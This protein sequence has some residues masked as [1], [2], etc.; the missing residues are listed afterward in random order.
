[1][2]RKF[3]VGRIANSFSK[4]ALDSRLKVSL[5][6]T[7][8]ILCFTVRTNAQNTIS[9][10][11]GGGTNSGAANSAYLP[12]VA[13][14]VRDAHGNTY[15]SV[16]SLQYI[17]KVN[18]AGTISV[19]AG[20]GIAG[21]SGDG[22]PA[23]L[24]KLDNPEGL[25]IDSSGNL[26]VADLFNY[27]VRRIDG[28]TGT[29]STVAGSGG[30]PGGYAG[31]GG[32]ATS[33]LLNLPEAVAVD[34][35]GNLF[36][37]DTDNHVVRKVDNSA[38]H[39]I[40]TYAG[41]GTSGT[42]GAANGDGGPATEAQLDSPYGV[43]VDSA[44]IVFIADTLDSV[45]RK[46][47][48][49]SSHIIT[50]YAGSP[51]T[52]YTSGGDGG[53]ATAAGLSNPY[54]VFVDALDN[55]FIADTS[56]NRIRKVD[57]STGHIIST[58]A[59]S[60]TV[61]SVSGTG[62]G[63]GGTATSAM[64]NAPRAT[65]EDGT[66]ALL[67]ID[68]GHQRVRIVTAGA[69]PTISNFAGGGNGGDGGP[70]LNAIVEAL[71]VD[72]DSSG[73]VFILDDAG[74]RVR[75]VDATTN[76]ITT[77]AGTG[78]QGVYGS[79]NGNN[80]PATQG[81][82][83]SPEGM[84]IDSSG[85]LYVADTF[86]FAVR[87]I[88]AATQI[89][90]TVAGNGLACAVASSTC[91]DGAL[92]TSANL[93]PLGVA[94]DAAGNIYIADNLAN[95]I[96][97]VDA[98]TG[99]IANFAGT[100]TRGY[101]GD[102][103]PASAATMNSPF[104]MAFD[105][106]GNLYFVD[107]GNNVVRKIDTTA[108]HTI[109]TVAFNGEPTFGGD[110]G[111]ALSASMSGPDEVAVDSR[112]N[113]FVGG[114][115]DNVVQRVD[116]V[117]Q[118]IATVA[119]DINDL[120]G[121]FSGDGGPATK[122]L[123]ANFGLALDT[124]HNLFIADDTHVR[125]VHMTP[126]ASIVA[127]FVPFATTV[128]GH[129]SSEQIVSI[130][131]T[132][133]DDL[134][135]TGVS[136][137]ANF[138]LI[139]G[140][141]VAVAPTSSCSIGV[142][143]NPAAG[144]AGTISG[145]LTFSTDD[146]ANPTLSYALS[147]VAVNTGFTLTV[148]L[149]PGETG[150]GSV[151]SSPGGINCPGTAC[152]A[153]F[154]SGDVVLLF[155]SPFPGSI[156]TGWTG[157]CITT[158]PLEC[159]VTMSAAESVTATFSSPPTVT[160]SI[161]ANGLGTGTVTSTPAG[162][163][164]PA[165]CTAAF[166]SGTSLTLTAAPA[167]GSVFKGWMGNFCTAT[168]TG[169]CSLVVT[170]GIPA[171]FEQVTAVFG[172][173]AQPFEA[174]QVFVGTSSNMVYVYSPTGTLV[175]I[176]SSSH[177]SCPIDG[178]TFDAS[179]NLFATNNGCNTAEIYANSGAG[180]TILGSGVTHSSSVVI[181]PFG[182]IFVGQNDATNATVLE[183]AGAT[184]PTPKA[185]FFPATE[186]A[187]TAWIELLDDEH[188]LLYTSASQSVK[189]FDLSNSLQNPDFAVGLPGP[190]AYALR[191]LPDK[192]ILVANTDRIVRLNT[193]GVVIQTYM[194]PPTAPGIFYSLNLDPDLVTFW[195][196]DNAGGVV[197]RFNIATG[198]IA[199]QFHTALG[200]NTTTGLGGIAGIAIFGQPA[201]GGADLAISAS[202]PSSEARGTLLTYTITATNNGPLA[203]PGVTITDTLPGG[204]SASS[205]TGPCTGTTT[206]ACSIGTLASGAS[207][208]VTIAVTPSA[209]GSLMNMASVTSGQPDPNLS[210]NTASVSTTITGT[211]SETLTV[212]K[213]G[214]G[215]G[216]VTSAPAG[217]NCGA[218]CS[219]TFTS[220]TVVVLAATETSGSTFS[221]WS[222]ACT[223]VTGACSVT[224][225]ETQAVTAT[226]TATSSSGSPGPFAYVPIFGAGTVSVFDV[227]TN[228]QVATILVGAGPYDA[229]VSPN[230]SFVYV[231][232]FG[233][234]SVSVINT[235]TNNVVAT[236]PVGAA[237]TGVAITPDSSLIY[238]AN[239]SSNTVSIIK[240]ATNTVI[241]TIPVG[242]MPLVL[243]ATP[244]GKSIYGTN[245][246]SPGLS[247]INVATDAVSAVPIG[248]GTVGIA[249]SPDGKF[250]YVAG[251]GV[252]VVDLSS[253][254]ISSSIPVNDWLLS[255]SPKGDRAYVSDFVSSVAVLDLT[256][257][258]VIATIPVGSVPQGSAVTPDGALLWQT[259]SSS[260]FISI[261]STASNT[262]AM[263]LPVGGSA[264][265]VAMG[266]APPTTQTITQPLSPTAPNQ[267]N[268][269]PHSFTAQYPAG[270]S[271][272]GVNMTVAAVQISQAAFARRVA[273]TT[274]SAARCLVYSGAGGN[275][276]DYEVTCTNSSGASIT[277]PNETTP[278]IAVKTSFGTAQ[279]VTN[280]GFLTTPIGANAWQNIF[281]GFELQRIDPTMKG[282]TSGFSEFVAIDLGA[283]NTQG[284]ATFQ[285]EAPLLASNPRSF[286]SGTTVPVQFQLTSVAHA[287]V[288]VTDATAG[289]SMLMIADAHGNPVSNVV[290]EQAAA[291]AYQTS[292]QSYLYSLNTF[293][294]AAGVYNIT[295]YGNAF[296][297]QQ[298][299]I[300]L[301]P[302]VV[303]EVLTVAKTGSGTGAVT[304]SPAGINCGATCTAGYPAGTVVTL[305]ATQAAGST[306]SGWSGACTN[307]AGP[308]NVAMSAG[309]SVTA[310]FT[311]V[312]TP[313][314]AGPFAYVGN[315]TSPGC[316]TLSVLDTSSNLIVA[317]IPITS[318]S[319]PFGISPDQKHL[320]VAVGTAVDVIDTTTNSLVGTITGVGPGANSA[321]IAPNGL[322]GYVG[323][324]GTSTGSVSVFSTATNKVVTT[325]P[326]GFPVGGVNV[327]PNG[328]FAYASGTGSTIAVINTSTNTVVSTFSIPVPA[329]GLNGNSG[330][331][332]NS[333]GTLGYV[334]QDVA[335][336]TP[337]T[338]TV[339]SI[340]SNTK[341]ATIQVGTQPEDIVMTPDGAYAYVSNV[342]SNNVSVIDTSNNTVIATVPVGNQPRAIA[343]T[344]N[345]AAAYVGNLASSTLSVIQTSTNTVV[346]TIPMTAP[347]GSL[348]PS[349]SP[350]SQSIT[351]PLSPT[352]PNPFNF[353][354]HAFT[355]QYPAGTSFSG[356]TMTVTAAQITQAAFKQRV[357]PTT[358]SGATCLVYT[359][360]G[361]NCVDYEVTCANSSG[362]SITCPS[363]ATPTIA[364]KTGFSTAQ[365][366]TNPG[367]LT[368]PIGTNTWQNIFTEFELQQV[369]PTMKGRTT[370]F[371]EFVAVDLGAT[372]P[373][374]L[375]QLQFQ[376]PLLASEPRS[377]VTGTAIP[378]QFQLTSVAHPGQ[379]V[380]DA[381]AGI[382]VVLLTDAN[383]NA[384]NT[385]VL[386][387]GTAFAYQS[388]TQNYQYTLNT[389]GYAAG[390]YAVTVFGNA[391][392]A[393]QVQFTLTSTP[394]IN[395][396]T[397]LQ[398]LT[399]NTAANQYVAVLSVSNAGNAT[400]NS[401]TITAAGLNGTATATKLPLSIGNAVPGTSVAATVVFPASAGAPG[402]RGELTISETYTGGSAG[403]GLRVT[404]P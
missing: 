307:A 302:A 299:Q 100:G 11:A 57:N 197:Y 4:L 237:P 64:L 232:N 397:T 212:A 59:G 17:Y 87:R 90:T 198:A 135:V 308:C 43:A 189:S 230:G 206:I 159:S 148:A 341:V 355:V 99:I 332:F 314:T 194:P 265:H 201:S 288:P 225:N 252:D 13:S 146:A 110:G 207:S 122:A 399:L 296:A 195:T 354:P 145:T 132:G 7:L 28:G 223:N 245:Q 278:T 312:S 382:S 325:V 97:R 391:F 292:T 76:T 56:N 35:S 95:R 211:V 79:L 340:P 215:S 155:A 160:V 68:S 360:A 113:I 176:L 395:L 301:L 44:G 254:T 236:I 221:G 140:C 321:T 185:T 280:P 363:E 246:S 294:Y 310:M 205:L 53:P 24:A 267:F 343:I 369:D 104:G 85:N 275:C 136:V 297:A 331:V 134:N 388:A 172:G 106:E 78:V 55:L 365:S 179:G 392:V 32:P 374:G 143:F 25:A 281:S 304:S 335:S 396:V 373:Q 202:A 156:F 404:L 352:A 30:Y 293:G 131:N 41:N 390:T 133:L 283:T 259:N 269:G 184:S 400:A 182:D 40:S 298:V 81:S 384:L 295:V 289:I 309:E 203:A 174:G 129:A 250:A 228:L 286:T 368:T 222:G 214:T 138:G 284:A 47:D 84:T 229:A 23:T 162:I 151:G 216:T 144:V 276:V 98:T 71:I 287:A 347:F 218:T 367:F 82:F 31:D 333:R 70:A 385:V 338:V 6:L 193:S 249:I 3:D 16:P 89:I 351:Q 381:S 170:G 361:G 386:E 371:S 108:E 177:E 10:I 34:S 139:N 242:S 91:G 233:G 243:A 15:I 153:S 128:A 178:M 337:G 137:T 165:T 69:T 244:D 366:I 372:N 149:A 234:N 42:A 39:I 240:A 255:L 279:L 339:I 166:T 290:L 12:G 26:Y 328:A 118:T 370:G 72:V 285:F 93:E 274:F 268:F 305:T 187:G 344:P 22:G 114:G 190:A 112:G 142:T 196:G 21:F 342:G 158:A 253:N 50:T 121:G 316:C 319:Y 270:T 317:T 186:N 248:A 127:A 334:A 163:N 88:D 48:T 263:N 1:M 123:I 107:S 101:T 115:F 52:I 217:I 266:A 398:S 220:G 251:N 306:F 19:Y 273:S 350:T 94:V 73:N 37:A 403:S 231:T 364:V 169:T 376:A 18:G 126:V 375:G 226:F 36:I 63:D 238:I 282:R 379:P 380:T 46:V 241:A 29:I 60:S 359:G 168:A 120:D 262:V 83:T 75:R 62:C 377:F 130:T 260:T 272:S 349:A 161:A 54:G 239:H 188:T 345:G 271:F 8:L 61:C 67:V 324:G 315:V 14:A 147:G 346:A 394:V 116:A 152:S 111:P 213:N 318:L 311:T 322:F 264:I 38:E 157:P 291:F 164:C 45:V 303:S 51:A 378:V 300:T 181:D 80:V 109:T 210:N 49:S 96:R 154:G 320:Y 5:G 227:T 200:V 173:A 65:F 209:G 313:P 74:L 103:G 2:N 77:Y 257:N 180:P 167:A 277:C 9:S 387:Q 256:S 66:G 208:T 356:V 383:G 235:I 58:I 323:N 102:A 247:L 199:S 105:S 124:S 358:F 171:G 357:A 327:T 125:K 33:A 401:V 92:A 183:F 258:T 175:Q 362:A 20:T 117:S 393:Q 389:S 402:S 326:I 119:G 150:T 204:L 329:G 224:M 141:T 336:V 219:A 27:R 348:I 191:E 261:I 353:G 192:T 86:D 330:P